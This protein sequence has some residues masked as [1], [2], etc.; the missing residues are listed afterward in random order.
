MNNSY[1]ATRIQVMR[2][3]LIKRADYERL[4]KMSE[5]EIIGY[6]QA[7]E[8]REDIDAIALKDLDDLETVDKIIARNTDRLLKKLKSISSKEFMDELLRTLHENDKWNIKVIAESIIGEKDAKDMLNR[9]AKRGTFDPQQFANVKT[10]EELSKHASRKVPELRNHPKT[11]TELIDALGVS[12]LRGHTTS[13]AYLIDERNLAKLLM[14]KR[15]KVSPDQIVK[16]LERRGTVSKGILREAANAA[17]LQDTIKAL[18]STKYATLV[19]SANLSLV[20]FEYDLH[21]DILKRIRRVSGTYPL[22]ADVLVRYLAE[23][24]IESS[25][26]RLLI[27]GKRLGLEEAFLK[28]QLVV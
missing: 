7:T 23:K 13:D 15:D 19:D 11:F 25:N 20:K 18:R 1:S 21:H 12:K 9:Y 17:S 24:D 5:M 27:K 26:L 8:Y 16:R 10:L 2:A 22:S 4:L 28:E 3:K 6:L 14:L